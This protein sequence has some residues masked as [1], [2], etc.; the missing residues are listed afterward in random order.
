MDPSLFDYR[1]DIGA[2]V[3]K[4][5]LSVLPVIELLGQV[6][7]KPFWSHDIDKNIIEMVKTEYRPPKN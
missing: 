1:I 3:V 6:V 7:L 2:F 5:I 4:F